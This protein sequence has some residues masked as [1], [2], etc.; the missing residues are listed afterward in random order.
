MK[1]KKAIFFVVLLVFF[2]AAAG[3]TSAPA[4]TLG[5]K[6]APTS[7][8]GACPVTIKFM[9]SVTA[10]EA[11][12]VSVRAVRSDGWKGEARSLRFEK[13]GTQTFESEA[14]WNDSFKGWV[15]LAAE[16]APPG[17]INMLAK[18]L[19]FESNKVNL[20]I[21]C[22]PSYDIRG[23]WTID[24]LDQLSSPA[25]HDIFHVT[26]SGNNPGSGYAESTDQ[27]VLVA[28]SYRCGLSS[29]ASVEFVGATSTRQWV[30]S[31]HFT[32]QNAMTGTLT[33]VNLEPNAN[34]KSRPG[35]PWT[36]VRN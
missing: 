26:F 6:A 4:V 27:K 1:T 29:P 31:G 22:V 28:G 18:P 12:V 36:A 14:K 11:C 24:L 8:T 20:S 32:A 35:G 19:T 34:P 3:S 10:G 15:A 5:L 2:A 33:E 17:R 13:P 16:I 25:V 30:F 9:A 7:H 23:T 21:T